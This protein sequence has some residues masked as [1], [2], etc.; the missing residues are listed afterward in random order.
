[1]IFFNNRENHR[2]FFIMIGIYKIENKINGKVYIGQSKDIERRWEEHKSCR[3]PNA[4]LTIVFQKYGVSNFDFSVIEEC[5][6]DELDEREK[7]WIQ[8]YNSFEDGYNLTRGGN[9][10]FYYD[11]YAIWE[12]FQQTQNIAQT[13]KIIGCHKSTARNVIHAFGVN[14]EEQQFAKPVLKIDPITLQVIN[15]YPSIHDAAEANHISRAA[16]TKVINGHGVSSGG[17]LW[18]TKDSD[19]SMLQPT[20]IKYFRR[21]VAQ[22][23]KDT[24][25]IINIY[26]SIAEAAIALNKDKKT[27]SPSICSVCKGKNKSAYGYKWKYIDEI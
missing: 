1:M 10:G 19:L 13:A 4:I 27:A 21:K 26:D 9:S 15:E 20:E 5:Q 3:K 2:R 6:Q 7:Y 8:Y 23:D 14:L 12:V 22:I 18:K 16:I 24:D 17:F 11:I 25:K